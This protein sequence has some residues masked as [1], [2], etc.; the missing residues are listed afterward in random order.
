MQG[1]PFSVSATALLQLVTEKASM[2][3]MRLIQLKKQQKS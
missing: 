3:Y 2:A 1:S